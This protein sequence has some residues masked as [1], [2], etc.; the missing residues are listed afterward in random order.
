MNGQDQKRHDALNRLAQEEMS[1]GTYD[2]VIL[3]EE[4][5]ERQVRSRFKHIYVSPYGGIWT[6]ETE[7]AGLLGN[8]WQELWEE[9][10]KS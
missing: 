10:I 9:Y 3:P 1:D 6:D 7:S 5:Y 4:E 8:T 2:L